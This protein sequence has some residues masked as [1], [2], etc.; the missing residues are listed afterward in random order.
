MPTDIE[1]MDQLI[2]TATPEALETVRLLALAASKHPEPKIREKGETVLAL[3]REQ[4]T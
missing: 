1:Q 3:I 4:R 2:R